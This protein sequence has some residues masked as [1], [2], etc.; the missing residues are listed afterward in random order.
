[1]FAGQYFDALP[2]P[3]M[4]PVPLTDEVAEMRRQAL[5]DGKAARDIPIPQSR[6]DNGA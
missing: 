1:M 4:R 6:P 5:I 2:V 3:A